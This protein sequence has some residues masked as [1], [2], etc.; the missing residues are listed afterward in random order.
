LQ[1]DMAQKFGERLE[2]ELEELIEE[3]SLSNVIMMILSV[4]IHMLIGL[5]SA[6][7]NWL[8]QCIRR[9]SMPPDT[10]SHHKSIVLEEE[11]GKIPSQCSSSL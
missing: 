8:G 6:L 10:S 4:G 3:P 7:L 9:S 2:V 5:V 1:I 11:N